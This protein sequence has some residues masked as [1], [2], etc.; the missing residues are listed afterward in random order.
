MWESL[1][2]LIRFRARGVTPPCDYICQGATYALS[3]L[4]ITEDTPIAFGLITADTLE[5]AKDRVGGR[6]GHKGEEAAV[7]ALEMCGVFDQI[8]GAST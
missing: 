6:H 5:Q 2:G 3:R 1:P 4:A 7:A 8:A